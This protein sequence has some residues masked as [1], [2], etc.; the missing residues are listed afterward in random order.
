[1]TAIGWFFLAFTVANIIYFGWIVGM[2]LMVGITC[3]IMM[4]PLIPR[5]KKFGRRDKA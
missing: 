4:K 5:V 2:A 1:M 3:Y